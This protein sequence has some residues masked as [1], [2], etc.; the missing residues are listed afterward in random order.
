MWETTWPILDP[1]QCRNRSLSRVKSLLSVK[2][3]GKSFRNFLLKSEKEI[4]PKCWSI[5]STVHVEN[6]LIYPTSSRSLSWVHTGLPLCTDLKI[7]GMI[8]PSLYYRWW[9]ILICLL[10]FIA[11]LLPPYFHGKSTCMHAMEYFKVTSRK[12]LCGSNHR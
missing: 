2:S 9:Y 6:Y 11:V 8:H 5:V 10:R 12:W 3:M 4:R 7:Q 1:S